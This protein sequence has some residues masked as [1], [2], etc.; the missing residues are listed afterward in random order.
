M[1]I[2]NCFDVCSGVC[3]GATPARM[4]LH[5]GCLPHETKAPLANAGS[6]STLL[7]RPFERTSDNLQMLSGATT[8]WETR[9]DSLAQNTCIV[10][11]TIRDTKAKFVGIRS[12]V[13]LSR[14]LW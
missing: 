3:W 4:E 9:P 11:S 5:S 2:P 13:S 10:A 7:Y 14:R 1:R 12:F 8:W 6:Q